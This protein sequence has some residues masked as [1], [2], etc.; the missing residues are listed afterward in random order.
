[1][2][3]NDTVYLGGA[4][5]KKE[6]VA[7][8]GFEEKKGG[9]RNGAILLNP[10]TAKEKKAT[11]RRKKLE[12]L[13]KGELVVAGAL[14]ATLLGMGV[15]AIGAAAKTVG[16][17]AAKLAAK[18]PIKTLFGVGL[19]ATPG[20][21]KLLKDIPKKT[22][23]AGKVVGKIY[24]GEETGLTVGK[25]LKTAGVI[26]AAAVGTKLVYDYVT[27]KWKKE[28]VEAPSL[29]GLKDVGIVGATPMG[30]GGVPLV[31]GVPMNGLKPSGVQM[32]RPPVQNIIQ[33]AVR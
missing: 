11:E 22:V 1:M 33:I 14:G 8:L 7:Y 15:P 6:G 27:G 10:I 5:P 16:I 3:A 24:G 9:E 19:A 18:H 31:G 4:K 21:L 12:K 26:G 2:I 32:T 20:G 13:V 23:E 29:P 25:A 17:G 30:V 28:K